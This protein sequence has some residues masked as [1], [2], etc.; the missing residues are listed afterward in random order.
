MHEEGDSVTNRLKAI[1]DLMNSEQN[2]SNDNDVLE[3]TEDDL[4]DD[5][6]D[7]DFVP[8]EVD[9]NQNNIANVNE[10]LTKM[11]QYSSKAANEIKTH[12]A[13]ND[14]NLIADASA[15]KSVESLKSLIKKLEK[16]TA[17]IAKNTKKVTLEEVVTDTL[18]PYLKDWLSQ[19]LHS[20][21]Q[22]IVDKEVQKLVIKKD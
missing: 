6:Q 12:A 7:E 5:Q 17:D 1:K 10:N 21:V 3:L 15:A 14:K 20:I 19:Y 22:E 13:D 2:I 11:P 18:R 16:T 9:A 8:T 4:Y